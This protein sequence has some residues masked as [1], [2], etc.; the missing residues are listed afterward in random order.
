MPVVQTSFITVKHDRANL[1]HKLNALFASC[2][3]GARYT[4]ARGDVQA[5]LTIRSINFYIII[6]R[7]GKYCNGNK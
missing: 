2:R 7:L 4:T 1:S 5:L 6:I 3:G